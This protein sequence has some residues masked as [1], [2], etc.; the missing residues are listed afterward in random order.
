MSKPLTILVTR[1]EP[2][3][4][5]LCRA[6]EVLGD[7]AIPFPTIAFAPPPDITSFHAAIQQLGNQSWLI[8]ISPQ[9]VTASVP[10]IRQ[11][12]PNLPPS[13]QFAAVGAGTAKALRAA[14]YDSAVQPDGEWSSE[15]LLAM[16]EFQQVRDM[17]IA[18][19]RGVG[20]REMLDRELAA[21]GAKLL[22]VIA[23]ERVLPKTEV[24]PCIHAL[25]TGQIHLVVCTSFESVNNLKKRLDKSVW[26]LLEKIPL[27]VMSERVKLLAEGLGFRTIW[28]TQNASQTAIVDLIAERRNE[29]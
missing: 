7:H 27:I 18:I 3:C 9:A 12:W 5:E 24:T 4:S 23:Y 28:V 10:A 14:G 29:L 8:F 13:V 26:P 20:G 6:I 17:P 2:H 1:P 16:P 22:P 15:G 19:V 21:R 25:K 11:A